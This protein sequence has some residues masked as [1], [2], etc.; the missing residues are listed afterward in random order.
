MN[1]GLF[2]QTA[3]RFPHLLAGLF[4]VQLLGLQEAGQAIDRQRLV[5]RH[6]RR[7]DDA[8]QLGGVRLAGHAAAPAARR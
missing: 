3:E 8:L 6:Q 4:N 1:G 5:G 2:G 7:L